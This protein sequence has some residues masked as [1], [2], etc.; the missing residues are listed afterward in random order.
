MRQLRLVLIYIIAF[1]IVVGRRT[2]RVIEIKWSEEKGRKILIIS[3][4]TVILII[5]ISFVCWWRVCN[6][7]NEIIKAQVTL[8]L[9]GEIWDEPTVNVVDNDKNVTRMITNIDGVYEAEVKDDIEK[10][11]RVQ[12]LDMSLDISKYATND[13]NEEIII[14]ANNSINTLEYYTVTLYSEDLIEPYDIE[15]FRKNAIYDKIPINQ[16]NGR[17]ISYWTSKDNNNDIEIPFAVDEPVALFAHFYDAQAEIGE[18]SK[19]NEITYRMPEFTIVG[20][21]D[22]DTINTISFEIGEIAEDDAM[23]DL[24]NVGNNLSTGDGTNAASITFA[25][26]STMKEVQD[27]VRQ[28]VEIVTNQD[29][30]DKIEVSIIGEKN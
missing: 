19:V 10:T 7:A 21:S 28:N 23:I 12:V 25:T 9:D 22:F 15:I 26:P 4:C 18:L 14:D 8:K 1:F 2:K 27:Y 6:E 17:N 24:S 20:Y 29:V 16:M 3:A 30:T 5:A 11:Y 13:N